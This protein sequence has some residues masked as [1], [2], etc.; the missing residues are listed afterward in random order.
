MARTLSAVAAL[1]IA[2]PA[3]SRLPAARAVVTRVPL[4][5]AKGKPAHAT[6]LIGQ[7]VDVLAKVG[8]DLRVRTRGPVRIEGLIP[9]RQAGICAAKQAPVRLTPSGDPVGYVPKGWCF[10]ILKELEDDVRLVDPTWGLIFL[11]ETRNLG[12]DVDYARRMDPI[13]AG[14]VDYRIQPQPMPVK[15]GAK[16]FFTVPQGEWPM[17]STHEEGGHAFIEILGEVVVLQGWELTTS[18]YAD[19]FRTKDTVE[20]ARR[21]L[22]QNQPVKDP[23]KWYELTKKSTL[24]QAPG[25]GP[26]GEIDRGVAVTLGR[27]SGNWHQ[28]RIEEKGRDSKPLRR[29]TANLWVQG[30]VLREKR[31]AFDVN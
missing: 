27:R 19:L 31:Q 2:A 21:R 14:F 11:A 8:V 17:R 18:L 10:R 7:A 1:C 28:L 20:L 26:C 30:A 24:F 9:A 15:P 6:L 4:T 25:R 16:P 13:L 23:R 12:A 22:A 5:A 29:L 3:S